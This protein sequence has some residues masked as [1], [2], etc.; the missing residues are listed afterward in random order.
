MDS[1]IVEVV[2]QKKS[3]LPVLMLVTT[4][5][6]GNSNLADQPPITGQERT[7]R[8]MVIISLS[9]IHISEPTRRYA[10]SYAVFCLKKKN[11]VR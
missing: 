10:I 11:F 9:L 5:E 2:Q 3:T 4:L 8:L 6:K 7:T 1:I